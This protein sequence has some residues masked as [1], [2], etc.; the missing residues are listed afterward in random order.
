VLAARGIDSLLLPHEL[1]VAVPGGA[2]GVPA[3]LAAAEV[4]GR[5]TGEKLLSVIRDG[6]TVTT[7]EP[8]LEAAVRRGQQALDARPAVR[9]E[10]VLVPA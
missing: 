3:I 9:P 6:H 1:A 4:P 7:I 5:V 10:P 8:A 2:A